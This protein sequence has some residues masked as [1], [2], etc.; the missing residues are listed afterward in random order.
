M[1]YLILF[2]IS[3]LF[4]VSC[5]SCNDH[6]TYLDERTMEECRVTY[7]NRHLHNLAHVEDDS[8][9]YCTHRND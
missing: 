2:A 7:L 4:L 6:I 1:R 9:Y 8:L 3:I 5:A